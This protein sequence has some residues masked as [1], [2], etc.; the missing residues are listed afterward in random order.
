METTGDQQ[1][2]AKRRFDLEQI[3]LTF[4]KKTVTDEVKR[5][6]F[7]AVDK[8]CDRMQGQVSAMFNKY[9]IGIQTQLADQQ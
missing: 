9:D 7:D 5:E 2:A 8:A 3:S 1:A 6:P 4:D